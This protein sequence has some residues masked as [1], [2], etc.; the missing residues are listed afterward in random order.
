MTILEVGVPV[1]AVSEG[2]LVASVIGLTTVVVLA[3]AYFVKKIQSSTFVADLFSTSTV[4]AKGRVTSRTPRD[5]ASS[6]VRFAGEF[7]ARRVELWLLYGQFMLAALFLGT[8]G[9]LIGVGK[10]KGET[11]MPVLATVIGI[12]LGKTLLS[13]KGNPLDANLEPPPPNGGNGSELKPGDGD[14]VPAHQQ[15]DDAKK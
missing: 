8:V 5:P 4:D 9:I 10:I 2:R 12:V 7:I 6:A 14:V 13:A 1:E 11:G 15:S 3:L